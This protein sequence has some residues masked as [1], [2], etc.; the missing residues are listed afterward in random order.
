MCLRAEFSVSV[1]FSIRRSLAPSRLD[2]KNLE[3]T[4][5]EMVK[6]NIVVVIDLESVITNYVAF[7]SNFSHRYFQIGGVTVLDQLMLR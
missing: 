5:V 3:L 7:Y 1:V 4:V 6:A 2:S